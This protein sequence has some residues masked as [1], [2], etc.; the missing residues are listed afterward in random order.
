MLQFV[1]GVKCLSKNTLEY[2]LSSFLGYLYFTIYI[3]DYFYFN[4]FIKKIMYFL[5]FTLS[6]TPKSTRYILNA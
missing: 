5:L 1:S 6:L 3:L 2:Y 4:T